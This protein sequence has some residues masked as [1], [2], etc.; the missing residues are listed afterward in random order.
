[1]AATLASAYRIKRKRRSLRRR[2]SGRTVYAYTSGNP[3]NRIDPSGLLWYG[4][5]FS[6]T[7]RAARSSG[8]GFRDSLRLAWKVM[9]VDWRPN[10]QE[11]KSYATKLHAMASPDQSC[12]DAKK[13]ADDLIA[14]KDPEYANDLAARIHAAQDASAPWHYG[15]TWDGNM[16][17]GHV[18]NDVSYGDEVGGAAYDATIG[19]LGGGP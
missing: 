16:S 13:A 4:G 15:Q 12:P 1:M 7:Y 2:A 5:H 17:F 8:F 6:I 10:S 3:V 18:W 11:P 9:A 14:G 19:I